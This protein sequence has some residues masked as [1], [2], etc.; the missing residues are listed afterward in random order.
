MASSRSFGANLAIVVFFGAF[1]VF[2]GIALFITAEGAY[3]GYTSRSWPDTEGIIDA[4][5]IQ[6]VAK[7]K[8]QKKHRLIIA[9][10][11]TVDGAQYLSSKTQFLDN[12]FSPKTKKDQI[13]ATFRP[14]QKVRVTYNPSD[15]QISVLITGFPIGT[16]LG[17][18][19]L[20]LLFLGLGLW[21][22]ILL[23]R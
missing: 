10:H 9:Y 18:L 21:G 19:F 12:V 14:D 1:A 11:Y 5:Y 2:G 13:V 23:R 17:G 7:D 22:L 4:S 20:G 16:F 8:G 3:R 15:P 6:T